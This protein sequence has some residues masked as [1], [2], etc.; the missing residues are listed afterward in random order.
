MNDAVV[1]KRSATHKPL[2]S[3]CI[4]THNQQHYI[5]DA[6]MSVLVQRMPSAFDL[7]ILVGDDASTDATPAILQELAA[8]YPGSI[9]VVTHWPNVGAAQNYQSLMR[10][11]QGDYVAH[12]D[13]DDYWLPG[14]LAAQ[15]E[16]M[17]QH[18]ACVAVYTSAVVVDSEG[19]LIGAFS[20]TQPREFGT[21]YLLQ[22]GNFLNHSSLLYRATAA[23]V[24]WNLV[25][26]FVDYRIHLELAKDGS[27]G[28]INSSFVAYRA[29]TST[30]MLRTMPIHVRD[31]YFQAFADAL[32]RVSH[33]IQ[34]AALGSYLAS[35][36][37]ASL[38]EAKDDHLLERVSLLR[39]RMK[40][41]LG[42]LAVITF[43]RILVVVLAGV[44]LRIARIFN[45]GNQLVIVHPRR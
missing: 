26:P 5:R 20:N 32:P 11:A 22:R 6:V 13:G 30:S 4:A 37:V 25:P 41:P 44:G 29:A 43:A 18:S 45:P 21:D 34:V 24:L 36:L 9:T 27:L 28:H 12:L 10:R 3:V 2:I 35:A 15:L 1:L 40:L 33:R 14:K 31:L 7:E 8:Q 19:G 16:F 42:Q 23:S 17:I 39:R 38:I